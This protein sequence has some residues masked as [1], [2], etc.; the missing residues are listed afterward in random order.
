MAEEKFC[1]NLDGLIKLFI[2][3]IDW[4]KSEGVK[5]SLNTVILTFGHQYVLN[6]P[7]HEQITKFIE[8]SYEYWPAIKER[9]EFFLMENAGI[10]FDGIPAQY[11]SEVTR[12]LSEKDENGDFLIPANPT[13]D[14]IWKYLEVLVKNSIYYIH[15]YRCPDRVKGGY[16]NSYFGMVKDLEGNIITKGISVRENALLWG[17]TIN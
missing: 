11:I 1:K 9:N 16:K 4:L 2:D 8:K 6:S 7:K 10:L 17:I 5:T 3:T 14:S 15:E 12:L 13:R